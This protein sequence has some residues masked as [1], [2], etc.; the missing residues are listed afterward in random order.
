[1]YLSREGGEKAEMGNPYLKVNQIAFD[2]NSSRNAKWVNRHC[3]PVIT[4]EET[5]HY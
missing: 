3:T 2:L 4:R 1:M 5:L